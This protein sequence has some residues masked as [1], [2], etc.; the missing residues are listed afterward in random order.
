A[1]ESSMTASTTGATVGSP[2]ETP[3]VTGTDGDLQAQAKGTWTPGTEKGDGG[4]VAYIECCGGFVREEVGT[5]ETRK[6]ARRAAKE[7]A[8]EA[9]GVVDGPGC[10]P[11]FVLC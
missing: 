8:D 4:W 1:D 7:A 2:P 5:Y 11:P 10:D 9:N 3:S 6:E